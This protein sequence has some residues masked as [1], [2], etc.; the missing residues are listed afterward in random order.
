MYQRIGDFSFFVLTAILI[1]NLLTAV[2]IW[3]EIY[4]VANDSTTET[5][6]AIYLDAAAATA[7]AIWIVGTIEAVMV[8]HKLI[9][10]KYL[11]NRFNEGEARGLE[12]G[13]RE[14]REEGIKE[15]RKEGREEGQNTGREQAYDEWGAWYRRMLEAR[16]RGEDFEEPPPQA[17]RD[18]AGE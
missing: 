7:V 5:I 16:K 4:Y 13:L 8:L 2:A 10:E 6:K 11:A 3:Y 18:Q 12:R 1:A 9:L 15:G 17:S 14:G